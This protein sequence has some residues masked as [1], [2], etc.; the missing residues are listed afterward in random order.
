MAEAVERIARSG[1]YEWLRIMPVVDKGR[2][3][4]QIRIGDYKNRTKNF[5]DAVPMIRA[6]ASDAMM[7]AEAEYA[8]RTDSEEDKKLGEPLGAVLSRNWLALLVRH[9]PDL[10]SLIDLFDDDFRIH[11]SLLVGAVAD[12]VEDYSWR[13]KADLAKVESLLDV[14]PEF[15]CAQM[16]AALL[17][18]DDADDYEDETLHLVSLCTEGLPSIEGDNA[19]G[20]DEILV[21]NIRELNNAAKDWFRSMHEHEPTRAGTTSSGGGGS[22]F[23]IYG[24]WVSGGT[25]RGRN[26]KPPSE[27]QLAK[28]RL[29][30][31]MGGVASADAL[32]QIP[33][34]AECREQVRCVFARV[35]FCWICFVLFFFP[36]CATDPLAT[37]MTANSQLAPETRNQATLFELGRCHFFKGDSKKVLAALVSLS[38]EAFSLPTARWCSEKAVTLVTDAATAVVTSQTEIRRILSVVTSHLDRNLFLTHNLLHALLVAVSDPCRTDPSQPPSMVSV[39]KNDQ[40]WADVFRWL[41]TDANEWAGR[42]FGWFFFFFFFFYAVVVVVVSRFFFEGGGRDLEPFWSLAGFSR[43]INH[44]PPFRALSHLPPPF[45]RLFSE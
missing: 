44:L 6:L 9:C 19:E 17:K 16:G 33:Y 29:E 5:N 22:G 13:K 21:A 8:A 3:N 2:G 43:F 30:A 15:R 36:L 34:F 1:S 41:G 31:M 45:P 10:D 23:G 40:I 18:N 24:A 27:E 37:P 12:K 11:A 14:I 35:G 32:L 26:R 7:D 39:L 20:L 4:P 38:F 42:R 25:R 28:E